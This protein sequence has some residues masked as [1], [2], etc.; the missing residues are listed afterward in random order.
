LNPRKLTSAQREALLARRNEWLNQIEPSSLF[1][2]LLDLVPGVYFFAKNR[3]GELMLSGARNLKMYHV[4]DPAEL[5]GLTD[6]DLNPAPM[7]QAYVEDDAR[8]YATGE[9]ILHRAE[10]W[11]DELGMPDWFLVCKLPLRARD[12][13]GA[14][15][16]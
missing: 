3:Q 9:P 7:A 2:P 14:P 10:L 6:F 1:Y 13:T 16:C 12:G 11:F 8:I 5:V 4:G 15:N